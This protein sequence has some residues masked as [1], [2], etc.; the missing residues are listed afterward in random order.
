[1]VFDVSKELHGKSAEEFY[2][3]SDKCI[4]HHSHSISTEVMITALVFC[5]L[6]A[7]LFICDA[8]NSKII[9]RITCILTKNVHT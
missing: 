5:H 1:M 3:V 2:R 4:V 9:H 7:N 8:Q 6:V